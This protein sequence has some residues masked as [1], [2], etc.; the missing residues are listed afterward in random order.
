VFVGYEP[1]Q[2]LAYNV[3]QHSIQRHSKQTVAVIPLRLDHMPIKRRGLTEFTYSRFLV[4][5]LSG[6]THQSVFMDADIVVKADIAGLFD[7]IDLTCSVQV[8]KNQAQFEWAS[9]ML[10]NNYK[11]QTLTPQY[12]ADESNVLFDLAWAQ[13]VGELPAEWNHC[14]GYAEPKE[15]KLYHY[16]QGLPCWYESR[17]LPE[18]AHWIEEHKEMLRTCQ[19]SELMGTSVHAKPVI[20]RMLR[21]LGADPA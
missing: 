12:V 11:C 16:T 14:V 8:Q 9:V 18:D 6:Y 13:K 2:P 5:Y 20:K 1:R 15:A 10:F 3:L 17:G 21:R 19:W 4:P 7:C